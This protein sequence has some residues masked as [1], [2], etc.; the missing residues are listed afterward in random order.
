MNKRQKIIALNDRFNLG[1]TADHQ[2]C[3]AGHG[4]CVERGALKQ[5][6]G[7]PRQIRRHPYIALESAGEQIALD[8]F[9]DGRPR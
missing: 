1:K 3:L 9:L 4:Q 7:L 6:L 2:A 8:R 5:L